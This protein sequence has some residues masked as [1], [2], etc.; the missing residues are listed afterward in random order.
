[1]AGPGLR[2][3]F[4]EVIDDKQPEKIEGHNDYVEPEATSAPF[5]GRAKSQMNLAADK[6]APYASRL[7][8]K[9]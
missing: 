1:M 2:A 9:I 6:F 8:T 3:G 7:T 5:S 4:T